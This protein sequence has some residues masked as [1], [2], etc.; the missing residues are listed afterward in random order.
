MSLLTWKVRAVVVGVWLLTTGTLAMA[1]SV[2]ECGSIKPGYDV[3]GTAYM[4]FHAD[5]GGVYEIQVAPGD[6]AYTPG[7]RVKFQQGVG[8]CTAHVP[9]RRQL[10]C[11][12]HSNVFRD[13]RLLH[14]DL[15]LRAR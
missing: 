14:L 7:N 3:P 1:Q 11:R 12:H 9:W 2:D 13:D 6:A 8:T 4:V 5:S 10:H 15:R